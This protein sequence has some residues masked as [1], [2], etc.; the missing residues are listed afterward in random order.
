M[1]S[2]RWAPAG[3]S[4]IWSRSALDSRAHQGD[5]LGGLGGPGRER[6]ARLERAGQRVEQPARLGQA[7]GE[8][9][10][11]RQRQVLGACW[12]RADRG[13]GWRGVRPRPARRGRR[14]R[15]SRAGSSRSLTAFQK[16]SATVRSLVIATCSACDSLSTARST[17]PRSARRWATHSPQGVQVGLGLGRLDRH[18]EPSG[19][20]RARR[21]PGSGWLCGTAVIARR[22]GSGEPARARAARRAS[23]CRSPSTAPSASRSAMT[24]LT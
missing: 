7:D 23:G 18:A 8:R 22:P 15:S 20:R 1:A 4:G 3:T 24:R 13:S 17:S 16:V 14:R 12:S 2:S 21:L 6:G 5:P 19:R 11:R 9:A 10:A